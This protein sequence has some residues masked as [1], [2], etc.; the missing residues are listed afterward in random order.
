MI[1]TTLLPNRVLTVDLNDYPLPPVAQILAF[2]A[3]MAEH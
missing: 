1:S 2:L 3:W